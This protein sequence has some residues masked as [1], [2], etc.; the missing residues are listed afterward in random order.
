[1]QL[2]FVALQDAHGPEPW[3][4]ADMTEGF[5][6][7]F[8]AKEPGW[9]GFLNA[10]KENWIVAVRHDAV[11]RGE[12]WMHGG[13]QSVLDFVRQQ[14]AQWQWW[15]N[16]YIVRPPASIQ[17]LN[18]DDLFEA[19]SP[20]PQAKEQLNVRVRCAWRNTPQGL[21]KEPIYELMELKLDGQPLQTEL[22]S[23]RRPN[24][25]FD[26][27]FHL[28]SLP[29][30]NSGSHVLRAFLRHIGSGKSFEVEQEFQL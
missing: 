14:A 23:K 2:P 20:N 24:G 13:S 30:L 19:G 29:K 11:S 8:L 25:L 18:S 7:L 6:T 26:E 17:L 10:L 1:M 16:P 21:A 28:A 27:H 3:W 4:F 9:D 15:D 12:T 5:R 22:K